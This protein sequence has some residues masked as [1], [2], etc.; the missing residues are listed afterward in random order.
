MSGLEVVT[1]CQDPATALRWI[2]LLGAV[3]AL[4]TA[5]GRLAMR[6]LFR[7]NGLLAW[8]ILKQRAA[9]RRTPQRTATLGMLMGYRAVLAQLVLR[10]G[11]AA[12]LLH[13]NL[14][15]L[16]CAGLCLLLTL[17][18]LLWKWRQDPF[19]VHG[20]DHMQSLLWTTLAMIYAGRHFSPDADLIR[21]GLLF[22]AA[23]LLLSYWVGGLAK[24][25]D[26]VWRQGSIWLVLHR[27]GLLQNKTARAGLRRRPWS[28]LAAW[29]VILIELAAPLMILL[30][31]P[32]L[33]L[34]LSG[35]LIFHLLNAWLL[36]IHDFTLAW[37]AFFPAVVFTAGQVAAGF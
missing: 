29:V 21:P 9:K 27:N 22:L 2:T 5:L 17:L 19:G 3:A 33:T 31:T 16:A 18:L 25:T 7:D 4:Q 11:A 13:P 14:P 32:W 10:C 23:M 28:R 15:P 12:L 20:N 34:A 36:E 26:P 8:P 24:S 37:L 35:F 1:A 30:P 6:H